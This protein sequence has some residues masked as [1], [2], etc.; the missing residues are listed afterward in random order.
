[1][2]ADPGGA[3]AVVDGVTE[4]LADDDASVH[5]LGLDLAELDAPDRLIRASKDACGHPIGTS[6]L[7]ISYGV[8]CQ[9]GPLDGRGIGAS[10]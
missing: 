10:G 6:V 7:L 8:G 4:A 5:H 2:G 1:M 3:Q 9:T